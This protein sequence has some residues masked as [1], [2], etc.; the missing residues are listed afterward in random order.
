MNYK[1]IYPKN[2][3]QLFDGGLNSKYEKALIGDNESPDCQNVIFSK[4]AVET[5]GGVTKL[6][7]QAIATAV[8]DGLYTR[9]T[10][11]GG[12]TMIAFAHGSA[13]TLQST[14][15]ATIGSAQSVFTAGVRVG[16]AQMENHAFFGNGYVIPYKYNGTDWT[17]HGVYPPTTTMVAGTAPTGNALTGAF[18]YKLTNVNTALVESDVGHI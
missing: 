3:A 4:G 9:R 18:R 16:S 7:T 17:R 2:G 1:R 10:N 12:E 11:A 6:N 13:W 5:R 8:G 15:F 14:T